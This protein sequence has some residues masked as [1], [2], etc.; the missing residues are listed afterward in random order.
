MNGLTVL[1]GRPT[2]DRD[3]I[4]D[5]QCVG[6]IARRDLAADIWTCRNPD[7]IRLAANVLTD[8]R[9]YVSR[10]AKSIAKGQQ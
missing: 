9:Q 10:K 2:E 1:S 7:V 5:L 4:R 3:A 6:L 8:A